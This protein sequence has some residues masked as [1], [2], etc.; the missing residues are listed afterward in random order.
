MCED[1]KIILQALVQSELDR[2]EAMQ[3]SD[4]PD[5]LVIAQASLVVQL[6]TI[7]EVLET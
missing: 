6:L 3:P 2:Q 7:Q 1:H 4:V 5:D